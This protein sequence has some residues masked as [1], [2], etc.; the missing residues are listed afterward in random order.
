MCGVLFVEQAQESAQIS[1]H[2]VIDRSCAGGGR[3]V[4]LVRAATNLAGHL[5]VAI[6]KGWRCYDGALTHSLALLD[7]IAARTSQKVV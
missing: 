3:S 5:I 6:P 7:L 2:A 1:V 4:R